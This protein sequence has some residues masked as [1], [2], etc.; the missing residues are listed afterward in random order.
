M[1]FIGP[2]LTIVILARLPAALGLY[3]IAST[4]FS[5]GQQWYINKKLPPLTT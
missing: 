3:W 1:L 4:L 5:I 2:I